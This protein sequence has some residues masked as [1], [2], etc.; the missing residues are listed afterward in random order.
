MDEPQPQCPTKKKISS[1]HILDH[2]SAAFHHHSIQVGLPKAAFRDADCTFLVS[3]SVHNFPN[4]KWT[5]A[6][7]NVK[8]PACKAGLPGHLPVKA[9]SSKEI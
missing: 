4:R 5:A 9:Q 1:P 2:K 7:S 8:L 6:M 3:L